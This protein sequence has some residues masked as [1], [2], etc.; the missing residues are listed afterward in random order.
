MSLLSDIEAA[1]VDSN[2]PIADLLRKCKVLANRLQHAKF[3]EW[4]HWELNGYPAT[5]VE[6]PR[7]RILG[8]ASVG[9][10]VGA[11]GRE[12]VNA[13][14]P[15]LRF[16]EQVRNMVARLQ[17]REA[18][19][20][21][22]ALGR[23]KDLLTRKWPADLVNF[24]A[25]NFP[26]YEDMTLADAKSPVSPSAF[27]AIA[28]IVRTRVLDFVLAIE[29]ENPSAGEPATTKDALPPVK[30]QTVTNIF[31]STIIGGNSNIG[32]TGNATIDNSDP[33]TAITLEHAK[34]TQLESLVTKAR[35]E[36]A[37]LGDAETVATI[38]RI[39]AAAKEK[40]FTAA[41]VKAWASTLQTV[42]TTAT[43]VAPNVYALAHWLA[44]VL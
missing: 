9:H 26:L 7:Y 2:V 6:L 18:I 16:P 33:S 12:I 35:D 8:V 27:H 4:V 31:N 30:A 21:V 39:S 25:S 1:A 19:S 22:E 40:K 5:E 14:I 13:P 20:E 24:V 42:A 28:D 41:N 38:E 15:M 29:R 23:S 34:L 44:H 10:F 43:V 3:A 36:A 37:A 17:V 11:F 32:T